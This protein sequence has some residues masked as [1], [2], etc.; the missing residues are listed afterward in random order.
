[1]TI[2]KCYYK[3]V[4]QCAERLSFFGVRDGFYPK[5]YLA[6]RD[7]FRTVVRPLIQKGKT[8]YFLVDAL[9]FE[10]GKELVEILGKD[11]RCE[12]YP[13]VAQLPTITE[14]GMAALM[15]LAE[16]GLK[17][18]EMGRGKVG[19][20]LEGTVLKG[21]SQRVDFLQ[22]AMEQGTVVL[23]LNQLMKPSKKVKEG[24]K[25][26]QFILVT[27]QEIDRLGEENWDSEETKRYIDEVLVKLKRAINC[28]SSPGISNIVLT[29][30]H[31]YV[32]TEKIED[33][34]KLDAPGGR[35]AE[36][37]PRV[38]IGQGGSDGQGFAGPGPASLPWKAIL[39]WPFPW[40]SHISKARAGQ[41][42][43]STVGYPFKRF[44]SQSSNLNAKILN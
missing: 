22:K 39:S 6:Q 31:G 40:G 33:F 16:K 5:R 32:F 35:T 41:A 11:F 17:L 2:D 12:I 20:G 38:W 43:F 26:A 27:S 14:V 18:V 19:I 4:G 29:S 8:A 3:V 10:M 1:M 37:H 25:D 44:S 13:A 42:D 34:M 24:I 23:K 15:P 30:D 21:R 36:L 9:R 7:I 28:V